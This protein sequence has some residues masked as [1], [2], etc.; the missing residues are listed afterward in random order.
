M[1][2]IPELTSE[3]WSKLIDSEDWKILDPDGWDR[4]NFQYSWYEERITINE[5]RK[6]CMTSTMMTKLNKYPVDDLVIKYGIN[7]EYVA[8]VKKEK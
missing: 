8:I 4:K 5:F 7:H 1:R 3:D 2:N 6:R